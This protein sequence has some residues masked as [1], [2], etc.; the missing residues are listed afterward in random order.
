MFPVMSCNKRYINVIGAP[1]QVG[2]RVRINSTSNDDTFDESFCGELGKVVY[3][4][5]DC[6]CGQ[7]FPND[8]MIGVCF[9]EGKVEEFWKEELKLMQS[10]DKDLCP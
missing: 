1:F 10:Y 2:D 4:E 9:Y 8:P 7:S 6:G 3:L 5:Y